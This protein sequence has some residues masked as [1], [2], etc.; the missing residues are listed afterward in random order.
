[1]HTYIHTIT[2]F[3]F[4]HVNETIS[5][6]SVFS[7]RWYAERNGSNKYMKNSIT[8]KHIFKVI[9][10]IKVYCPLKLKVTRIYIHMKRL[11]KS[12]QKD[13]EIP[14]NTAD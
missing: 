8:L 4:G 14:F 10:K 12:S 9:D 11:W 1:M 13:T 2:I 6:G 3:Y 7:E 5:F